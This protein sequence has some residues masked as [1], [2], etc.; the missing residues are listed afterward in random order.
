MACCGKPQLTLLVSQVC[1][2]I[3]VAIISYV[4]SVFSTFGLGN[5]GTT[6]WS[7]NPKSCSQL[8]ISAQK[9]MQKCYYESLKVSSSVLNLLVMVNNYV[10]NY[11]AHVN[12]M[13]QKIVNYIKE[14]N[15]KHRKVWE[16]QLHLMQC[17]CDQKH[18]ASVPWIQWDFVWYMEH[19]DKSFCF[20]AHFAFNSTQVI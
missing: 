18:L 17:D 6:L 14:Q 3:C 19:I 16:W 12:A 5:P 10:R 7:W 13:S 15:R 9:Q 4:C 8:L 1:V 20:V 2:R 11:S